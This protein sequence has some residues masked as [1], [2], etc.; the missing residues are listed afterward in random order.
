MAR[1]LVAPTD[2][3]APG[4]R[5]RVSF[6][7][8]M[9]SV[10]VLIETDGSFAVENACPHHGSS[11]DGGEV[12]TT[13]VVCP[14]HFWRIDFRTGTCLHNPNVRAQTF[15]VVDDPDGNTYVEVPDELLEVRESLW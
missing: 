8:G 1:L 14:W 6:P 13:H 11:F 2:A 9:K 15:P 7:A 4:M 5:R 12:T 10:L 3:L